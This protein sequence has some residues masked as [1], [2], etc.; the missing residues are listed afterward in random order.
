MGEKTIRKS[1]S[2]NA[3]R[4]YVMPV[5][6]TTC[7]ASRAWK[8]T[9]RKRAKLVSRTNQTNQ[10]AS[11]KAF[12][13][14]IRLDAKHLSSQSIRTEPTEPNRNQTNSNNPNQILFLS[15]LQDA[16]E[17]HNR[18]KTL[19]EIN[20]IGNCSDR[21]STERNYCETRSMTSLFPV[22]RQHYI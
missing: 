12:P 6:M 13:H 2:T 1:T 16:C 21:H 20:W 11:K 17:N 9:K 15:T 7:A 5:T 19:C 4:R 18:S 8:R 14:M 22:I 3:A 10:Q